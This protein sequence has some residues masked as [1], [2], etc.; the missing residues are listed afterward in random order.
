MSVHEL[1]RDIRNDPGFAPAIAHVESIPPRVADYGPVPAM[2]SPPARSY[3]ER[4]SIRPYSHQCR[5]METLREGKHLILTTPTASGKTLAFTLP[6]FDRLWED[7]DACAL[8]V[9]PT[10]ALTYDQLQAV[11]EMEEGTGISA[12]P[13]VYDGDTPREKRPR[14]RELSR[15]VLTNP[16]ELHHILPW[17]HQWAR[18][19]SH[20][21]FVVFDE[22]HRYRGVFGSQMA[23]LIRR[24]RRV[25]RHYGS[26]PQFVLST[27][28]LA[29]P[30]EFGERLCG[31]PFQVES[32]DGSPAGPRQF[33]L[34]NPFY[35][36][37]E[38]H[39]VH[40]ETADLVAACVRHGLQTLCFTGSRKIA[41]LVSTWTREALPPGPSGAAG[42]PGR[43]IAAYRA[44]YL[45]EE[46]R[47]IER[48]LKNGLLQAVVSTNA[49]EVGIDVG[50][51]D[52]VILSGYP[53]TMISTWQQAGRA[54][55]S[56]QESA[57]LMVGFANPLDQY[58][59]RHPGSFFSAGHEHAIIDLENPYILSG[60]VLC[61][62]AELPLSP[63][64]DGALFGPH[65]EGILTAHRDC[66]LV[67]PTRRGWVYS[68]SKRP[69]ELVGMGDGGRES[70]QVVCDG[71]VLETMDRA[72][73]F[74]E[75]HKGAVLL[76]QGDQYLV[77]EMD[78]SHHLVNVDKVEV[79]YYT[80]P[81]KSVEIEVVRTI[82]QRNENGIDLAFGEVRVTEQYYAYRIMQYDAILGV[83]PLELP[84]LSFVT[85]SLWFEV[86]ERIERQV[87]TSGGDLGGGMHGVE[88]A[89]I[90]MMPFH[91][92]CDRWDIG[93]LS[94]PFHPGFGAPV[95][96]VY[97]GYEG[98]IGLSEK[99]YR[100]FFDIC[101]TTRRL[102]RDCGCEEGCPACILSPKCGNDNQPLD[103]R[104]AMVILE[105]LLH[106]D[107][108]A[109]QGTA[110]SS[111]NEVVSGTSS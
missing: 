81:L 74:R 6:I 11:R 92:L 73:A 104:A 84:A 22:A 52:A 17:H 59:M 85:K 60:Q 43:G 49:L 7:P 18:F 19:F 16:Y 3:L 110:G 36:G 48:S 55:R 5:S 93:G 26:D 98:G 90:A 103:K 33:I 75:A 91:V 101:D 62:A 9:Y 23:Y 82:E 77:S 42:A 35:A 72:Q 13:A 70:Y 58:F 68:G 63:E 40:R 34:Y 111:G 57:A 87:R 71:S 66:S 56:G 38:G 61:A 100:I 2:L 29:N 24:L 109:L 8:L 39:S 65:L 108:P 78:L 51:L 20:L 64:T 46:R 32:R 4:R 14:I 88:H 83:E 54:G 47:E 45:P 53:G 96:F 69:A 37:V 30:G 28:T 89:F 1:L 21:Q 102:V 31:V 97:D 44:G 76:H 12:Y 94:T 15:V 67:R 99:A 50:S 79:D 80:R 86:P 25:C 105:G 95:I 27:A 41:E 107:D 106:R 10:K